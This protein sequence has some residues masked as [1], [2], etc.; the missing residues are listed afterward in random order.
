MQGNTKGQQPQEFKSVSA[1]PEIKVEDGEDKG[2]VEHLITVF[3]VLD[4]GRDVAHPG[5]FT[6]TI[7]EREDRIRVVD[8]HRRQTVEG[9]VGV[10]IKIWE[11]SRADL[12][13][14]VQDKY[15]EATGG[16]KALTQFLMDTVA[17]RET[18]LRIKAGAV[19]E[20]SYG[21]DTMDH[22]FTK[23]ADGKQVRNLRTIRLWEYGPV[24]FGLNQATEVVDV[25]SPQTP[26]PEQVPQGLLTSEEIEALTRHA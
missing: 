13:K 26:E 5:S 12:P 11:V 23:G 17:G 16:V 8:S 19:S 18:F 3:G 14:P 7:D 20:F 1:Y 22:D 10:P 21:Y 24:V 9:V 2:I 6:K 15:P 4:M 25:K